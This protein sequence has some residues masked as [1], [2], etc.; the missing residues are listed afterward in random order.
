MGYG[1][2]QHSIVERSIGWLTSHKQLEYSGE[3]REIVIVIESDSILCISYS[4]RI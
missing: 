2:K 1:R 3:G 4:N